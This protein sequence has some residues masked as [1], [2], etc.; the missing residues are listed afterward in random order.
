MIRTHVAPRARRFVFLFRLTGE[1]E[2][3][4]PERFH[5]LAA[6][7]AEDL[8]PRDVYGLDIR[9]RQLDADAIAA[10]HIERLEIVDVDF[11]GPVFAG[12][13]V[14]LRWTDD[15]DF[16]GRV[17]AALA[18]TAW[19]CAGPVICLDD[20]AVR[21]SIEFVTFP[22]ER[23]F[24]GPCFGENILLRLPHCE[25]YEAHVHAAVQAML[26]DAGVNVLYAYSTGRK[27]HVKLC[28]NSFAGTERPTLWQALFGK[29]PARSI[30]CLRGKALRVVAYREQLAVDEMFWR[31]PEITQ[32]DEH[33]VS[34]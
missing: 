14:T 11:L 15:A 21:Q 18:M 27:D 17:M 10:H 20:G 33:H 7:G 1:L 4:S 6:S 13:E 28:F 26:T 34:R 16:D 30:D 3:A 24:E 29:G 25:R 32:A 19:V 8:L 2:I 5:P 9:V 31:G 23:L 22:A 12:M